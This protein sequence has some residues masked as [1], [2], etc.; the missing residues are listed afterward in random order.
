[1]MA[2]RTWPSVE[3]AL[4]RDT[5]AIALSS[6]GGVG[7]RRRD[8]FRSVRMFTEDRERRELRQSKNGRAWPN[9]KLGYL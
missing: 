2:K 1:M 6:V 3:R 9:G 4:P 5:G 7:H 8:V